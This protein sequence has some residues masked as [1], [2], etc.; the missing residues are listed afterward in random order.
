M[1]WRDIEFNLSSLSEVP[2]DAPHKWGRSL[3][4]A[5]FGL[6][7]LLSFACA[8]ALGDSDEELELANRQV[9]GLRATDEASK[10]AA[11]RLRALQ[12]E[13]QTVLERIAERSQGFL[14]P[15]ELPDLLDLIADLSMR[16]AVDLESLEVEEVLSGQRLD[17]LPVSLSLRGAYQDIGF[18]HVELADLPWPITVGAVEVSAEAADGRT[19]EMRVRLLV[20]LLSSS[21]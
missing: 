7:A 9:L 17:L 14:L 16:R 20:P 18:F 3:R 8:W 1:H 6:S 12:V 21:A 4:L 13:E 15:D 2:W 5:S 11:Q 10:V 19:L